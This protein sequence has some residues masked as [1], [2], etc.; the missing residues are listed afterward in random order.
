MRRFFAFFLALSLISPAAR[1]GYCDTEARVAAF[2]EFL[3]A[4]PEKAGVEAFLRKNNVTFHYYKNASNLFVSVS[5][6]DCDRNYQ[7]IQNHFFIK[8][9]KGVAVSFSQAAATGGP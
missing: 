1:A 6:T 3:K 9:K 5:D 4:R 2:A 7:H 8:F